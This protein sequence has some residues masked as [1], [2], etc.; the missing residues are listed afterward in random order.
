ML[1]YLRLNCVSVFESYLEDNSILFKIDDNKLTAGTL[2]SWKT[3]VRILF[4]YGSI[5]LQVLNS[6]RPIPVPISPDLPSAFT[7]VSTQVHT[8]SE[9]KVV[10]TS[11]ISESEES[12]NPVL[13]PRMM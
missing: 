13:I 8:E 4:L 3:S 7:I 11:G 2:L 6:T 10:K 1:K 5:S 12:Q 9:K